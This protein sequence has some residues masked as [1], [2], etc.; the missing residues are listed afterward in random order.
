METNTFFVVIMIVLMIVFAISCLTDIALFILIYRTKFKIVENNQ[1]L[2]S[3]DKEI[4]EL[5]KGK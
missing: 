3:H 1:E 5:K 2:F 4:N